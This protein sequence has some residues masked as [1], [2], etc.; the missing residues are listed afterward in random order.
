MFIIEKRKS[1]SCFAENNFFFKCHGCK[2]C[3]TQ[4]CSSPSEWLESISS[5]KAIT[6]PQGKSPY[7]SVQHKR[8]YSPSIAIIT[9]GI[10]QFNNNDVR[11][12]QSSP[13]L[14]LLRFSQKGSFGRSPLFAKPQSHVMKINK[15]KLLIRFK[16]KGKCSGHCLL[17]KGKKEGIF[18]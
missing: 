6:V 10:Q 17:S 1:S 5:K 3:L 8:L 18:F 16:L 11:I 2:Y 4:K 9:A 12:A 7:K 15:S 13:L 14:A